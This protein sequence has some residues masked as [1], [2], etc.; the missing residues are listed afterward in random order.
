MFC[1]EH[2]LFQRLRNA[3]TSGGVLDIPT[4]EVVQK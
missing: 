2:V 3:Q 1:Y 4:S